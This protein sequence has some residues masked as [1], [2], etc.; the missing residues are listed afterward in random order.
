MKNDRKG[1]RREEGRRERELEGGRVPSYL[2]PK[3]LE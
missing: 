2:L 1:G 3:A